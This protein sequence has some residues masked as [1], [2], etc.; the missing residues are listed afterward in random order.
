MSNFIVIVKL[1]NL[2]TIILASASPRRSELL[3]SAGINFSIRVAGIDETQLP[4]ES[5]HDYVARLSC[6][7]ALAVAEVDEIV[8]GADTT[9]VIGNETAGKPVNIDDAKRM[10]KIAVHE[11]GH[12]FSIRHCTKYICVMSGAN[13]LGETDAHP[14]DVASGDLYEPFK[15][16]RGHRCAHQS[17]GRDVTSA[18]LTIDRM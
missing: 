8:L 10:L 3:R 9:V 4:N 15:M 7:K 18:V 2:P 14:I 6:E 13:H 16:E 17:D 12:I 11:T 5:P 1:M